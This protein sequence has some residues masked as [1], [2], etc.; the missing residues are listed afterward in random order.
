MIH[1]T[2]TDNTTGAIAVVQAEGWDRI[3]RLTL[4]FWQAVQQSLHLRS[5][6]A[7]HKTP[8]PVGGPPAI[9]TGNLAGAVL[10]DLDKQNL[11]GRVGLTKQA[12]YGLVHELSTRFP[13][14]WL[15]WTLEKVKPQL[16]KIAGK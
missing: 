7:P 2:T 15:L 1:V 14:P 9:R 13:R 6:P 5:N 3:R 11:V 16:M 4:F 10:Y 12:R 8:A